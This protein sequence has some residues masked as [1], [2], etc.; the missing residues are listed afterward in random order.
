MIYN[1]IMDFIRFWSEYEAKNQKITRLK[2]E[3]ELI[4]KFLGL[5]ENIKIMDRVNEK[6]T[7]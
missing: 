3:Q 1:G 4:R 2:I 6:E 7:K 5:D